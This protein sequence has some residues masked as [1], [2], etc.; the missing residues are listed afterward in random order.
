MPMVSVLMATWNRADV[1]GKA[2]QSV[3]DQSFQDWELLVVSDGSTDATDAVMAEWQRK[4]QRIK[5]ISIPHTG[6]IAAV[7][8]AGLKIAS[9]EFVAILDDDDWWIDPAK[10]EKQVSFL[11][12]HPDYVACGGGFIVVNAEGKET[13][14]ALK[15]ETNEAIKKVILSANPIANSSSMFRR[16]AAGYY[17]E[18]LQLADW[19]F[20]LSLGAKGKLYNFPEYFLAYRMWDEGISFKKQPALA[21][22]AVRI[23]KKHKGQY[24][25]FARAIFLA[26]S[27][28]CYAQLPLWIRKNLNTALSKA[29]KRM[30]S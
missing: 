12:E 2:I 22:A 26:R 23:V 27:Y 6:K 25:S 21:E 13:G 7:S 16:S 4:D 15:P 9:G 19:D 28:R 8:N 10:L 18:S 3:I 24:P 17:D 1:I 30:F 29:K 11:R 20:W 5:Y 14:R